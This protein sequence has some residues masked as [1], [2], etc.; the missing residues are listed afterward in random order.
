MRKTMKVSN[1]T[2]AQCA[3]S[4]ESYFKGLEE[5]DAKVMVT[6]KKVLFEYNE[7]KYDTNKLADH[8][9]IIGYYPILDNEA[10]LKA[11]RLDQIDLLLAFILTFPLLWTMFVHL[12]IP[13][14][15]PDILMNGYVQWAIAT[16]ILFYIGR[17]FFQA[18]YHQIKGRNLGMD[19][20][21]VMGT[22][23]AYIYSIITTLT[24]DSTMGHA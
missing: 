2:C 4:I 22:T 5:V 9:R 12:G 11:K 10:M 16:P 17:R 8:L 24:Y 6:S 19:T 15:V 14:Y 21:V 13:I 7:E 3:K 20:L 18:T 1:I 23:A